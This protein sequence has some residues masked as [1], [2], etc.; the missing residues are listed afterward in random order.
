M[1]EPADWL[2]EILFHKLI[3]P[4]SKHVS[5]TLSFRDE[6]RPCRSMS[7]KR[8]ACSLGTSSWRSSLASSPSSISFTYAV[9]VCASLAFFP[10]GL[11]TGNPGIAF[12][13]CEARVTNFG[14]PVLGCIEAVFQ[15]NTH[16][17][18]FE[19]YMY[20]NCTILRRF[21]LEIIFV[22][23]RQSSR[24][25]LTTSSLNYLQILQ[26]VGQTLAKNCLGSQRRIEE[27]NEYYKKDTDEDNNLNNENIEN[28][29]KHN[30][31]YFVLWPNV[32]TCW[33][34]S[35]NDNLTVKFRAE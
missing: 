7:F 28:L 25:K 31:T 22:T 30:A 21:K 23:I 33:Q 18:I 11:W 29:N 26:N 1:D 10:F 17:R 34:D 15:V 32:S 4:H 13:R 24:Q 8:S 3:W 19:I 5:S 12:R 27:T 20:T 9:N 14:G 16:C 35:T 2:Y 6:P